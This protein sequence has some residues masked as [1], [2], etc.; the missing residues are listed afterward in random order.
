MNIKNLKKSIKSTF[1]EIFL[2][3]DYGDF[4]RKPLPYLPTHTQKKYF[5]GY[6]PDEP[7]IQSFDQYQKFSQ[8]SEELLISLFASIGVEYLPEI[9]RYE[10]KF[11][12][13]IEV[14]KSFC[15]TFGTKEDAEV[16]DAQQLNQV[17]FKLKHMD[18]FREKYAFNSQPIYKALAKGDFNEADKLLITLKKA[19]TV[20]ENASLSVDNEQINNIIKNWHQEKVLKQIKLQQ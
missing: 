6:L 2:P 10:L 13:P 12:T 17:I 5:I 18:Q 19:Y 20:L 14:F 16:I 4:D 3:I 7:M 15:R 9:T 11:K 1:K 8:L